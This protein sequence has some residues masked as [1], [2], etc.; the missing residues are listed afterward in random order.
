MSTYNEAR[1]CYF[2]EQKIHYKMSRK[3]AIR[4]RFALY[5]VRDRWPGKKVITR[6]TEH[7]IRVEIRDALPDLLTN[8]IKWLNRLYNLTHDDEIKL[9]IK[10]LKHEYDND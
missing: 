4:F 9:F 1:K 5:K 7:G 3:L 8:T 2:R 10:K 6:L